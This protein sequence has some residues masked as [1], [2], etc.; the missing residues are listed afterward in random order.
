[1]EEQFDDM[2]NSLPIHNKTPEKIWNNAN[3][4]N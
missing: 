3:L 2:N 1:M 4:S